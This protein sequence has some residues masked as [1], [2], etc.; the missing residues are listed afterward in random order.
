MALAT[1]GLAHRRDRVLRTRGMANHGEWFVKPLADDVD[2]S[3]MPIR[4]DT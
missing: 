3:G 2:P 1:A 4:D